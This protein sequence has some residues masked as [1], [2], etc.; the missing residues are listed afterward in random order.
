MTEE[1]KDEHQKESD[2][3]NDNESGH[4]STDDIFKKKEAQ[5]KKGVFNFLFL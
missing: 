2:K 5:P 3:E 4:E 1:T